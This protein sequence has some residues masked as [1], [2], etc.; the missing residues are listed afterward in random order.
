MKRMA[1]IALG[2]MFGGALLVAP[3]QAS[4]P[5]CG[6]HSVPDPIMCPVKC[7]V[8]YFASLPSHLPN[9]PG[10]DCQSGN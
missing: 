9:V 8:N 5:H 1:T 7:N 3:A 4:D 6:I 10:N 2:A